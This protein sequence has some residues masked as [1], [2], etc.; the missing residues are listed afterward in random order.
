MVTPLLVMGGLDVF[1]IL[2]SAVTLW[3]TPGFTRR[4]LLFG[5]TV[6]P[7]ARATDAGRRI[8]RGY[9]L[10]VAGVAALALIALGLGLA[11]APASS[12]QSGVPTL[13]VLLIFVAYLV[14]YLLAYRA[15]RRLRVDSR[16]GA[17]E[18]V[19]REA[20]LRPRRYGEF[21]PLAWEIL[22]IALIVATAVYLAS[23]YPA[24]PAVIPTHW[25]LSGVA[26][27]FAA[28]SIGSFFAL[29]WTQIGM[30]VLLTGICLLV[31]RAKTQPGAASYRFLRVTLRFLFLLKSVILLVF[32]VVAALVSRAAARGGQPP[33]GFVLIVLVPI[34]LVVV[35]FLAV[36]IR[37]GQ[38]GA[39]LENTT[40]TQVDR[41]DDRYWLYGLF[42]VNR[43]DPSLLVQRRFGY[44]WTLNLGN[45]RSYIALAVVLAVPV[46]IAVLG[47]ATRAR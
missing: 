13:A 14:P 5:V 19:A 29:V 24:A 42:Y 18:S 21:V 28:K 32:D 41:M 22:P 47:V 38:G 8:I 23:L 37:I 4:D 6:A 1:L 12:W 44:G 27:R 34:L 9:R 7:N 17:V 30:Y 2:F 39:K 43:D 45:I 40:A 3:L 16:P 10:G 36:A 35:L 26:D 11:L 15:S 31:V 46:G 25:T 33:S 20:E